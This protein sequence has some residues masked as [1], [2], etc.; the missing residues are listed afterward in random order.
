MGWMMLAVMVM[1]LS[2]IVVHKKSRRRSFEVELYLKFR[3][4][5]R[6]AGF[7][8]DAGVAPLLL[9]DELSSASHPAH[10]RG[11][12]VVDYYLRSRFG[13][14]DLDALERQEMKT[15]LAD[16]RRALRRQR[17]PT[18]ARRSRF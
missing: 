14:Q 3:E 12:T 4:S 10:S 17:A 8:A 15:G 7:T 9:L 5:C 2:A 16:A 11:R 13:G 1:T 6:R 18:D